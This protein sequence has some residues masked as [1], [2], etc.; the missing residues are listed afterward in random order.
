[1]NEIATKKTMTTKEVAEA[2]KCNVK[3]VRENAKKCLP[4]KKIENGKPTFWN[5]A[6]VSVLLDFMKNNNNRT[7]LTCTTVVQVA[8]TNITPILKAEQFAE[9]LKNADSRQLSLFSM[10]F[11]SELQK[12]CDRLQKTCDEQSHA[13]E[14][15]K[16]I[17][18]RKWSEVKKEYHLKV[19]ADYIKQHFEKDSEWFL[20]VMGNDKFPT[21]WVSE[22]VINYLIE[23]EV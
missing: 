14:Y 10:V 21:L 3:T 23:S 15:S 16:A 8:Q 11:I 5:E 19:T 9:S 2:L 12:R 20:A 18:K 17:N 13:L 4:N 6:E 1:M 7:D 22:A